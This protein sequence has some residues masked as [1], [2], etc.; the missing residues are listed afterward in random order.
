MLIKP[1][2]LNSSAQIYFV[3]VKNVHCD[4]EVFSELCEQLLTAYTDSN[5]YE[6]LNISPTPFWQS[7]IQLNLLTAEKLYRSLFELIKT[8]TKATNGLVELS[9]VQY[10]PLELEYRNL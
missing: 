5:L 2:R 1:I 3:R 8:Y 10:N 9:I 7:G 6:T 4:E